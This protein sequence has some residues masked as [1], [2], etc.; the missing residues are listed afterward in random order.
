MKN[1]YVTR[2]VTRGV[3]RGVS[4]PDGHACVYISL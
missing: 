2:G 1:V 3:A 4:E